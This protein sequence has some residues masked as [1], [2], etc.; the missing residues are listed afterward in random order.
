MGDG[1][2]QERP[3][4]ARLDAQVVV[5]AA[6]NKE[7]ISKVLAETLSHIWFLINVSTDEWSDAGLQIL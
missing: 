6:N 2:R 1:G 5:P 7:W 4:G 3:P